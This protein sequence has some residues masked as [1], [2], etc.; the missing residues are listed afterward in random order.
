MKRMLINATQ[1]EEMRVA[2]VDGQ[3]IY[4]LDIESSTHE[5]KKANIY[6]GIITRIEPSLEAAFVDY[7]GDKHGFLPLK[8]IAREYFKPGFSYTDRSSLKDAIKEGQEIIV[9]VEKEER[10]LKG[11]ALTTY[12]SLAGSFIVL[13]PNNP[14]A[15]GISHRIEGEDRI[16]LKKAWDTLNVPEGMGVIVRTNA[17]GKT[18][19]E[20]N[21][22]LEILVKH[23]NMIKDAAAQKPAP[24]LI[25]QESNIIL[26]AVRDYLRQDIGEILVDNKEVFEQVKNHIAILRPDFVSKVHFFDD[27]VPL[28]THFQ[29]ES[30]IE[31]AYHREVKLPSG[32]SI[33]IDPTEAL[34]SIDVNSAKA[35][36]GGDIEE[37]AL[38]TNIEAAEEIA[39]QLRLR[40]VGGLVVVDFI[41][42]S[43]NK[44]Q[45]EIEN[46][47]KEAVQQDRARIQIARISRFGLMELSRQRLRP[48]L[49]E[50]TS[51]VCPRCSGQGTIRDNASL[52]LSILRVIEEEAMKSNSAHVC[53]RVPIEVAA[54]LMNEKRHAL[55]GIE[56]RH[57]VRVFILPDESLESPHYEINRMREG[58]NP[59]VHTFD[60]L[61]KNSSISNIPAPSNF[62]A[63][64]ED[65]SLSRPKNKQTEEAVVPA[66]NV[67]A[68][69][70]PM[71]NSSKQG[72]GIFKRIVTSIV[73]MFKSTEKE[74]EKDATPK[75]VPNNN[76]NG[77]GKK[78]PE[79]S[80][81]KANTRPPRSSKRH[82][83]ASK[84]RTSRNQH[85]TR[86]KQ[87][88]QNVE[89]PNTRKVVDRPIIEE[90]IEVKKQHPKQKPHEQILDELIEGIDAPTDA[91]SKNKKNNDKQQAK[92][93]KRNQK[94]VAPVQKPVAPVFVYE[95]PEKVGTVQNVTFVTVDMTEPE[96]CDLPEAPV[97][98]G[99][100]T[101]TAV[102]V[103]GKYAGFSAIAEV[104]HV[105]MTEPQPADLPPVEASTARDDTETYENEA[106]YAGVSVITNLTHVEMTEPQEVEMSALQGTKASEPTKP[107]EAEAPAPVVNEDVAPAEETTVVTEQVAVISDAEAV[108]ELVSEEVSEAKPKPHRPPRPKTAKPKAHPKKNVTET[109]DKE[110]DEASEP[111]KPRGRSN[112][113]HTPRGRAHTK[114]GKPP[115]RLSTP[116]RK[117]EEEPTES[118]TN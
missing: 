37:T 16:E 108:T 41:D 21:W 75:P 55:D 109:G 71:P 34:T 68:I 65:Q 5:Q 59:N 10:G 7:G 20:L 60:L 28:F 1:E 78:H 47:M 43:I 100:I 46:K 4:D 61:K 42:M 23:W 115:R 44:N 12:I 26:R 33:V 29:I 113:P 77:H 30:Q 39:R 3:K 25:H 52:A 99:V 38:Q 72:E 102:S 114:D 91:R 85:G 22:D 9:Q 62:P 106:G 45:R 36:K 32:G 87:R 14:R 76:S 116:R 94:P 64:H 95:A 51:H 111:R 15:G 54:F 79:H 117:K 56:K 101:D 84:E 31:S 13:M 66:I 48:S 88:N 93:K 40:D 18:P 97:S 74:E 89:A 98:A 6:K 80:N 2:L 11:A 103:S 35:T 70:Q 63:A 112:M 104:T 118:G 107:V 81:N 24:F 58:E 27:E 57:D 49:G 90:Q 73:G 83:E 8:E 19:E 50:S 69:T 96:P 82:D 86:D 67:T 110:A 53:A 17:V 105:D 92:N